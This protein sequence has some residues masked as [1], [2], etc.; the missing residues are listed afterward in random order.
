MRVTFVS[1]FYSRRPIGGIRVIYELANGLA[2]RGHQVRIIHPWDAAEGNLKSRVS[3]WID[4]VVALRG[5]RWTAVR[6]DVELVHVRRLSDATIPDG[7][8]I[9]ATSWRNAPAVWGLSH[10]K[11]QKH[12]LVMDFYP[13]LGDREVLESSWR[14]GF[15]MAAISNWLAEVIVEAGVDARLVTAISCGVSSGHRLRNPI[16]GRAP[17]VVMMYGLAS[18][19]AAYDGLR[20]L[21]IARSQF[22]KPFQ[23]H[24]FGPNVSRK[25]KEIPEWASY[26]PLLSDKGVSELYNK[27]SIFLSSSLAEGFCLPAAEAMMSGC[28]VVA[29]DCGGIR[30]FAIHGDNSLLSAP[31][32]PDLLA[33]S[34]LDVLEDEHL[35]CRLAKAGHAA[36]AGFTWDVAASKLENSFQ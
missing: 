18:Y 3:R 30:D 4:R 34:L 26:Q 7:D 27:S 28:A 5:V 32:R 2:A 36:I 9:L 15:R 10:T 6:P 35:R 11:G 12:N 13:Y 31:G 17:S 1:P 24:L 19:K 8:I 25:P 21:E 29:T 14:L 33:R 23:V 20:A 22:G 16:D